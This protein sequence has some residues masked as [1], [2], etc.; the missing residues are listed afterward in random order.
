MLLRQ[1]ENLKLVLQNARDSKGR[2]RGT[3]H[4]NVD[5]NFDAN[6]SPLIIRNKF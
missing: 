5:F 1:Q 4:T 2:R 3:A 6:L